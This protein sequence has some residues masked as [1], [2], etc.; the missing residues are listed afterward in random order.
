MFFSKSQKQTQTPF[1]KKK[2]KKIEF[3]PNFESVWYSIKVV[4]K[5]KG[6]QIYDIY[7][8]VFVALA[9]YF[10]EIKIIQFFVFIISYLCKLMTVTLF[11][12]K[13][14]ISYLSLAILN[15]LTN[16]QSQILSYSQTI[17]NFSTKITLTSN[18]CWILFIYHKQFEPWHYFQDNFEEACDF[19]KYNSYKILD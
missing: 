1:L 19:C 15:I 4:F 14:Y 12:Y 10:F 16:W 8:L 6:Y 2:K 9:L 7:F 11:L 18:F 5:S 13:Y 3:L 17:F